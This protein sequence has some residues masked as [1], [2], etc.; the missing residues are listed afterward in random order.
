[1]IALAATAAAAHEPACLPVAMCLTMITLPSWSQAI[2]CWRQP[3]VLPKVRVCLPVGVSRQATT[4][5]L[6]TS[7]PQQRSYK[8]CNPIAELLSRLLY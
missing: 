6:C 3:V 1:M 7:S 5:S 4:V 2:S 8:T